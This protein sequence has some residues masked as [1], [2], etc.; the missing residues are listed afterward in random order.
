MLSGAQKQSIPV[1]ITAAA[2]SSGPSPLSGFSFQ[3]IGQEPALLKR[4]APPSEIDNHLSSPTPSPPHSPKLGAMPTSR[5]SLLDLLGNTPNDV[6]GDD[7]HMQVEQPL[8]NS[9]DAIDIDMRGSANHAATILP[10]ADLVTHALG[11]GERVAVSPAVGGLSASVTA[12]IAAAA[13]SSPSPA[14]SVGASSSQAPSIASIAAAAPAPPTSS[15]TM[16][17]VG[18]VPR[19]PG[20]SPAPHTSAPASADLYA[21]L[22]QLAQEQADWSE[23]RALR[24]RCR[25][26]HQEL[27]ARS[28]ETIRVAQR[29]KDQAI[30]VVSITDSAFEKLESLRAKQEHRLVLE[31]EKVERMLAEA[32]RLFEE[33]QR[34][35]MQKMLE[36]QRQAEAERQAEAVRRAQAEA[37]A[38]E[39]E[40]RRVALEDEQRRAAEEAR[41]E[42]E[43]VKKREA[44][45]RQRQVNELWRRAEEEREAAE[46]R[47]EEQRKCEAEAAR[48]VEAEKEREAML[49]AEQTRK[50][51]QARLKTEE[52]REAERKRQ[53]ELEARQALQR[54]QIQEDKE[55]ASAEQRER[56]LSERQAVVRAR[57]EKEKSKEKSATPPVNT[58]PAVQADSQPASSSSSK[59]KT[60]LQIDTSH[61][62]S[63]TQGRPLSGGIMVNTTSPVG[64]NAPVASLPPKPLSPLEPKTRKGESNAGT[65]K[66][67]SPAQT[68]AIKSTA[69][70]QSRN[71]AGNRSSKSSPTNTTSSIVNGKSL[72]PAA[73]QGTV[74]SF[75]K[76]EKASI[77]QTPK[78][79]SSVKQ[80]L[81]TPLLPKTDGK[82]PKG[83]K[84]SSS[85]T[86]VLPKREQSLDYVDPSSKRE[87]KVDPTVPAVA[88]NGPLSFS[89]RSGRATSQEQRQAAASAIAHGNIN[90]A[91]FEAHSAVTAL[92][93]AEHMSATPPGLRPAP[94]PAVAASAQVSPSLAMRTADNAAGSMLTYPVMS[95]GE[96]QAYSDDLNA[97]NTT[98]VPDSY[99]PEDSPPLWRAGNTAD[100]RREVSDVRQ[101]YDRS[102]PSVNYERWYDHYSPTPT[103]PLFR[104]EISPPNPRKRP[105]DNETSYSNGSYDESSSRAP[106]RQRMSPPDDNSHRRRT[107]VPERRTERRRSRSP[108]VT[109]NYSR[110]A[111][112][113]YATAGPSYPLTYPPPAMTSDLHPV[114]AAPEIGEYAPA[115]AHVDDYDRRRVASGPSSAARQPQASRSRGPA[116]GSAPDTSAEQHT[117]ELLLRMSDPKQQRRAPAKA[118]R[119]G[120]GNDFAAGRQDDGQ[121]PMQP[122]RSRG[123]GGNT[124]ASRSGARPRDLASRM[125]S[126]KALALEA[127]LS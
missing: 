15:A 70:Q 55:R 65:G 54:K 104:R 3:I 99:P 58:S 127:R 12:G 105:R 50:A 27:L 85:A 29:E 8:S 44:E 90:S 39:H 37:E 101:R 67:A 116:T 48:K 40:R 81:L 32:Q 62:S 21:L 38:A 66:T 97:W 31:K 102:P 2:S 113:E 42:A 4:L 47:A 122:P 57:L 60:L 80:E 107:T 112:P 73:P 5:P 35:E 124:G 125:S 91:G 110:D 82:V 98:P 75:T 63:T 1:K 17:D 108:P 34:A 74:S 51:E 84:H 13:A 121:Q 86:P 111:A 106:R 46:L 16:S 83:L 19:Q 14:L 77:T 43:D 53:A 93:A 96:Y 120:N 69:P 56:I 28:E 24:E 92:R 115:N 76:S 126:G 41:R 78:R 10:S 45:E 87:A 88:G 119:G 59:A 72:Q 95:A 36:Q 100:D 123:R 18:F 23:I 22:S 71:V 64:Q 94:A 79:S 89:Q 109:G 61:S 117:P 103:H 68:T 20:T 33:M 52:E 26:E 114:R 11:Q 25:E 6:M 118:A 49:K 9:V 7:A 30:R